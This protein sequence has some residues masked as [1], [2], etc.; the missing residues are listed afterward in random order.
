MTDPRHP[1]LMIAASC[2]AV[3]VII[4]LT[5]GAI[6]SVPDIGRDLR[7]TQLELQWVSDS[8]PLVVAALLLP[9]GAVLDR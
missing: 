8:F 4:G 3:G 9:A 7:A 6:A 1:R 5:A 2:G